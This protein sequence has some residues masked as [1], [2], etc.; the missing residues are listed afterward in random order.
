LY[1]NPN[2]FTGLY[3][4]RINPDH[5]GIIWGRRHKKYH[6]GSHWIKC[7]K[8]FFNAIPVIIGVS[9][10]SWF[11]YAI[12]FLYNGLINIGLFGIIVG[13]F[14]S[15]LVYSV[16]MKTCSCFVCRT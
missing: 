2:E 10:L 15:I 16:P 3:I 13:V 12:G 5:V 11:D 8:V 6:K 4:E 1:K 14:T 9:F 7:A